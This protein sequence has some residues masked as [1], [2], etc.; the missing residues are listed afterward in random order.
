MGAGNPLGGSE[1]P[2]GR[3]SPGTPLSG[4]G[5]GPLVGEPQSCPVTVV[6]QLHWPR[7]EAC[8]KAAPRL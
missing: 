4:Q 1:Y 8:G 2:R 6:A 5:C 7:D 3:Y